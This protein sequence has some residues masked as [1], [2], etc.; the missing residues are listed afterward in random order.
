MWKTLA[1]VHIDYY[2]QL[3]LP[4]QSQGALAIEKIFYDFSSLLP[5]IQEL[6]DC[7]GS[8]NIRKV[9][10]MSLEGPPPIV[11]GTY[12]ACALQSLCQELVYKVEMETF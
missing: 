11:R 10:T 5:E 6:D 12:L 1:Q 8:R 3:Y 2:S 9:V 4:G 7:K